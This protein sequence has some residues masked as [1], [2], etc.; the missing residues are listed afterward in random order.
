MTKA[1]G[2]ATILTIVLTLI[3][4][5]PVL[6]KQPALPAEKP[7]PIT[8]APR[9]LAPIASQEPDIVVTPLE[10]SAEL[11]QNETGMEILTIRNMGAVTRTWEISETA[12]WLTTAPVSGTVAPQVTVVTG[13]VTAL[14]PGTA[15]VEV[16]LDAT[17]LAA[18][19]YVT[20]LTVTSDAPGES[21]IDVP[22]T[23]TVSARHIFLPIVLRQASGTLIFP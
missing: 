17:G 22:V 3:F 18:A 12:A 2:K 5:I 1:L 11:F 7:E 13:T 9:G 10:L 6:A 19:T 4:V 20:T 21:P 16:A 15:S 8:I 23:L 14:L